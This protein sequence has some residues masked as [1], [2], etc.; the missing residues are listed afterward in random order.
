MD[1]YVK[2]LLSNK[3]WV[4][5][6]LKLRKDFFEVGAR[7]QTPE[8]LWIGCSDSRVP[9]EDIT[10]SEPGELFVHRNIANQ[11]HPEDLNVLSVLQYAVAVLK[12]SHVI[13]CGHYNC[14]GVQRA[15]EHPDADE[16]VVDR[17][18]GQVRTIGRQ[19]ADEIAAL[20]DATARFDRLVELSVRAQVA[21]VASTAVVR[22]AWETE[23]RPKLHGLVYDLRTGYLKELETQEP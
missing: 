15:M 7:Q 20:G 12:V 18:L 8:F 13:V 16:G 21:R 9:A 1:N 19:H 5:E 14:G 22:Q 3:A 11:V 17:W 2:L 23:R 6:K 10:G 4:E